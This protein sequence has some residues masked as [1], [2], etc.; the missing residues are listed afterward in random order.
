MKFLTT[1]WVGAGALV[2]MTA[3]SSTAFSQDEKHVKLDSQETAFLRQ[4]AQDD[5]FMW[6]LAEYGAKHAAT[7]RVRQLAQ[8]IIKERR[9]DLRD[10]QQLAQD[11][12]AKVEQPENLTV[13]QRTVYDQLSTQAGE[14]FD[15]AY[16]KV[17]VQDYSTAIPQLERERDHAIHVEIREYA[18]KNVQMF[19]D[20]V[21]EAREAEKAVWGA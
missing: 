5:V 1:K 21:N 16:T 12:D 11:H 10:I 7:D 8:N 6:R 2:L 3:L 9:T 19:K 20:H 13:Q 17:V 4:R 15:K 18:A 14:N